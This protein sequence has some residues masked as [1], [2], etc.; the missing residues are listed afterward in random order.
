MNNNFQAV[1]GFLSSLEGEWRVRDLVNKILS[2]PTLHNNTTKHFHYYEG[3]ENP[4]RA[5]NTPVA[6][7]PETNQDINLN[8]IW[9]DISY[10]RSLKVKMLFNHLAAFEKQKTK[11][12]CPFDLM[13]AGTLDLSV[14]RNGKVYT[15]D[16]FRRT[17]LALLS[18]VEY[19]PATVTDL[20]EKTITEAKKIEAYAFKVKN[21]DS[22]AMKPEELF[23]SGC[24]WQDPESLIV[25]DALIDC[26]LDVLK[27]NPGN[28]T[29]GAFTSFRDDII[30]RDIGISYLSSAS[31]MIQEAW[32][33]DDNVTGYLL[34]GLARYLKLNDTKSILTEDSGYDHFP[35]DMIEEEDDLKAKLVEYVK[36]NNTSQKQ[37][38][39][40]AVK[41]RAADSI[42]YTFGSKVFNYKEWSSKI[43]DSLG[44]D[45]AL[46][47][48]V[49][50]LG[51]NKKEPTLEADI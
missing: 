45:E 16:G 20:T 5:N 3:K 32:P 21:G 10:Q 14:R 9:V 23:K 40:P 6:K 8:D 39:K 31:D 34:S 25:K 37:L 12:T 18:G 22:E 15:W 44:F 11:A 43:A 13:L 33:K 49:Q 4:Y 41:G 50:T 28:K 2:I 30:R 46:S 26:S 19:M 51:K 17:M 47:D 29:L 1:S 27:T 36:N 42:A 7:H 35:E 38:C 24:V 48:M